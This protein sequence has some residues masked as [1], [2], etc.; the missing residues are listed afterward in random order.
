MAKNAFLLPALALAAFTLAACQQSA[1][2][3][4]KVVATVN[5]TPITEKEL[6]DH[7]TRATGGGKL[8]EAGEQRQ[9]VLN[10]LIDRALLTQAAEKAGI[11][12]NPDI[13]IRLRRIRENAYIEELLRVSKE[14]VERRYREEAEKTH[15]TEYRVRHILVKDEADAKSIIE[16]LNKGASFAKLAKEK[17]I[18]TGSAA[19]GGELPGWI[20]QGMVVPEFFEGVM[21][22]RKGSYSEIPVKSSFGWHVIKVEDARPFKVPT[23]EQ[24]MA[25]RQAIE[26]LV[27]KMRYEKAESLLKDL[28]AKAK[29]ETKT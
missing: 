16:Q 15:K 4:S 7:Y 3:N 5:G 14:D 11:D 13:Q 12:K 2:D 24:F 25:D 22:T 29:I 1:P 23:L 26:R 27:M 6:A 8:P 28:R 18:D 21:K 19:N 20:N 17:S 10:E 9:E